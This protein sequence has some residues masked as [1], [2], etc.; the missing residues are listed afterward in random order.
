MFS[1]YAKAVVGAIVA[2][3]VAAGTG[4]LDGSINLPEGIAVATAFFVA[5]GAVWATP[6]RP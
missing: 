6:N 4:A 1:T 3:L 2:G 5:L